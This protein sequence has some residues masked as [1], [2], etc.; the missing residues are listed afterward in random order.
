MMKNMENNAIELNYEYLK[1]YG[2]NGIVIIHNIQNKK[3]VKI[4]KEIFSYF[5]IASDCRMEIDSFLKSFKN[6]EDRVYM[7][8]ITNI[9]YRSNIIKNSEYELNDV[10]IDIHFFKLFNPCTCYST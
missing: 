5:K 6:E 1:I 10:G 8:K 9:M 3:Y 7:N 4:T 2:K